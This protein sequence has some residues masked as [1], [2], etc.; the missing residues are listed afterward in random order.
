M[1]R[2]SRALASACAGIAAA[3]ATCHAAPARAGDEPEPVTDQRASA[4][5]VRSLDRC[6]VLARRHYPKVQEAQARLAGKRAQRSQ[7]ALTP[8]GDIVATAGAGTA[9]SVFGSPVFS[10]ST[11][12]SLSSN[13]ALAWR[14]GIDATLPLWTFGKLG[15]ATAA[16][17]AQVLAGAHE[18]RRERNAVEVDVRRAFWGVQLARDSLV[19][20]A[21]A[22]RRVEKH[23]R[24]LVAR[25]A[26]GEGD[27]VE[28]L[29]VEM[30]SAD[31]DVKESEGRKAQTT[32]LAALRM[33]VGG[34]AGCGVPDE[35]LA[36]TARA[37]GPL[38]T[39]LAAARLHRPEVNM[40]RAGVLARRALVELERARYLPDLGLALSGR[41]A[42]AP[43]VVDQRNPFV[44][45]DANFLVYGF[46]L[47]A[48]WKLDFLPQSARVAQA[49]AQLEEMRA[50]ER[51]ALG[52][53]GF[54]VEQAYAEASEA[55][56][57]LAAARRAA[58][59]A[60]QWLLRVQQ[61]I[62]VGTMED[63]K[64]VDPAREHALRR[65]GVLSATYDYNV[66]MARLAQAT[67][68]D[69]VL[70]T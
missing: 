60:R 51:F 2:L 31:L 22:R 39:Y 25:V 24:R 8:F 54:E 23:R 47:A 21:D 57:R 53:V 17:D 18:V 33:L 64:I 27:E 59:Y 35:P 5:A 55:A 65:F 10:P 20:L 26:E 37:L 38:P 29:K 30:Y 42:R 41:W 45:D 19:L 62:D 13:M 70:G 9:P 32:A 34:E 61:A 46:A 1:S 48:R 14:V 50:T 16:A 12:V 69:A 40:A 6:L 43:E 58:H 66:A 56:K 63:E 52:G 36:R 3:L 49:E 44:R 68:W 11:D 15:H 28:L 67:G 4:E 7:V